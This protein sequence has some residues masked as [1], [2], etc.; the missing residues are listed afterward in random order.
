M[1]VK[2]IKLSFCCHAHIISIDVISPLVLQTTKAD[3]LI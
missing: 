1:I 2:C 3:V